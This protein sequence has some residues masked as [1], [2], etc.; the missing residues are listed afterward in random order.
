MTKPSL[1]D[2]LNSIQTTGDN[3]MVDAEAE[4]AYEPFIINRGCAQS[5]DCVMW[6][7]EM[8]RHPGLP[9]EMHY[10]FLLK[11]ISKKKRYAKWNK[12]GATDSTVALVAEAFQVSMERAE[13]MLACL[14]EEEIAALV[15]SRDS[16]GV[17][18]K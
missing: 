8:N 11:S 9:K 14:T 16:G 18:K 7:Q 3:L 6:A 5:I 13:S 15:S 2:W 4:K 17:R 12:K 10:Q 1:F